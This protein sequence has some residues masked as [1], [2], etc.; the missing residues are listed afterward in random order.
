MNKFK[1]LLLALLS[2]SIVKAPAQTIDVVAATFGTN[3]ITTN[4]NIVVAN[5]TV[6]SGITNVIRFYDSAT[7]SISYTNGSYSNRVTI[8]P[9]TNTVIHTNSVGRINTNKYVGQY[10]YWT[11]VDASTNTYP[12]IGTIA[13]AAGVPVSIPVNWVI[14][15]GLF[16]VAIT[17]ATI[18]IEYY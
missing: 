3:T 15:R 12:V 11:N 2:L 18:S 1:L 5:V 14:A 7:N 9:Y 8:D 10:T 17:N 6:I 13:V 4:R 16:A